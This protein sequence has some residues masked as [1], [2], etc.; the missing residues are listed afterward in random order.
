V[1]LSGYGNTLFGMIPQLRYS[2]ETGFDYFAHGNRLVVTLIPL[3][4]DGDKPD[5][6][7]RVEYG[8]RGRVMVHRLDEMQFLPNLLERDTAVRI[9]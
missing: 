6:A 5:I 9:P 8:Q 4:E 7:G 3:C 2:S 1:I